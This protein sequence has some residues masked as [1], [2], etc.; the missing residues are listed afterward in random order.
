MQKVGLSHPSNQ[1]SEI[2]RV[3]LN[4]SVTKSAAPKAAEGQPQSKTCRNLRG[5]RSREASWTAAVLLSSLPAKWMTRHPSAS[6]LGS[7]ISLG[8]LSTAE[9]SCWTFIPNEIPRPQFR[10]P[11]RGGLFIADAM[12]NINFPFVFQR[13]E[14]RAAAALAI[15]RP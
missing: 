15:N 12:P 11:R 7:L 1:L 5:A 10:K 2:S 6:R 3:R 14:G 9:S 13:R 4:V 8:E